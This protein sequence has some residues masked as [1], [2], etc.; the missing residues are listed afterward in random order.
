MRETTETPTA[1]MYAIRKIPKNVPD[2]S[3]LTYWKDT[4]KPKEGEEV[5]KVI[6]KPIKENHGLK[7]K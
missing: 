5:V 2:F 1:I 3:T 7:T 4:L 6:I